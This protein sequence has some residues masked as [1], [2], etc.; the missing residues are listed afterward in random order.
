MTERKGDQEE[1]DT[2]G[3]E[4]RAGETEEELPKGKPWW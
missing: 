2:D 3:E 1:K 4:R